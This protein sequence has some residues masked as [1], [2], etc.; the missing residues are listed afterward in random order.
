MSNRDSVAGTI[1]PNLFINLR[2]K[3]YLKERRWLRFWAATGIILQAG[4]LAFSG[5]ATYHPR[6]KYAKEG[7]LVEPHAYPLAAVGTAILVF[8]MWLC[9][10]V[11]ESSTID[12]IWEVRNVKSTGLDS[13]KTPPPENVRIIWLQQGGSVTDQQ[14]DSYAIITGETVQSVLTS[15]LISWMRQEPIPDMP[16]QSDHTQHS[17]QF[18]HQNKSC[19]IANSMAQV[20][21]SKGFQILATA[22]AFIGIGG[23]VIQFTGFRSTHF[24]VTVAQLLVTAIMILIRAW[25]RR[26]LIAKPSAYKIP[27]GYEMD[28]LATRLALEPDKLWPSSRSHCPTS[29]KTQ[30]A[31]AFASTALS[32]IK[33]TVKHLQCRAS[34]DTNLSR[35]SPIDCSCNF[36]SESCWDWGVKSGQETES[37]WFRPQPSSIL[38]SSCHQTMKLRERIG[39][40]SKWAGPVTE[41]AISLSSAIEVVMNSL[42]KTEVSKFESIMTWTMQGLHTHGNTDDDGQIYFSIERQRGVWK[43]SAT[44][45][46]AFLSLWMFSIHSQRLEREQIADSQDTDRDWL[47][48]GENAITAPGLRLLGSTN[49]GS[50]YLRDLRWY[51]GDAFD[52][53]HTLKPVAPASNAH[54]GQ[55]RICTFEPQLI[56]GFEAPG[57]N[58]ASVQSVSSASTTPT[59]NAMMT[60]HLDPLEAHDTFPSTKRLPGSIPSNGRTLAVFSEAP[61]EYHLVQ[62]MFSTFFWAVARK[63]ARLSGTTTVLPD[64]K[65][66]STEDSGWESFRLQNDQLSRLVNDISAVSGGWLGNNDEI[67]LSIVPQLR[68]SDKLPIPVIVID[69]ARYIALPY[70]ASGSWRGVLPVYLFLQRCCRTFGIGSEMRRRTIANIMDF[71]SRMGIARREREDFNVDLD[72]ITDARDVELQLINA[73][74]QIEEDGDED[75]IHLLR[76]F[77]IQNRPL[78]DLEN[79]ILSK[80]PLLLQILRNQV[81]QERRELAFP[82]STPIHESILGVVR[83]ESS[84]EP[85]SRYNSTDWQLHQ[86]NQQDDFGLTPL[87][88]FLFHF[89]AAIWE[90]EFEK[91][92]N[93]IREGIENGKGAPTFNVDLADITGWSILHYAAVKNPTPL[94]KDVITNHHPDLI[95]ELPDP[96]DVGLLARF[97][98]LELP[99]RNSRHGFAPDLSGRTPFHYVRTKEQA[100]VLL[101]YGSSSLSKV[102]RDGT[103][104]LL[105]AT[106]YKREA[107]AEVLL[108]GNADPKASD[109]YRRTAFHWAA[110]HSFRQLP[111]KLKRKGADLFALDA[112]NRTPLHWSRLAEGM[113]LALWEMLSEDAETVDAGKRTVLHLGAMAG[114]LDLSPRGIFSRDPECW[115]PEKLFRKTELTVPIDNFDGRGLTALGKA[116]SRGHDRAVETLLDFGADINFTGL[117]FWGKPLQLAVSYGHLSTTKLLLSRGA[118]VT[119]GGEFGPGENAQFITRSGK[120]WVGTLTNAV[121]SGTALRIIPV[122]LEMRDE[123]RL[124]SHD[125]LKA[126]Q[127]AVARGDEEAAV[128]LIDIGCRIKPLHLGDTRS[129]QVN[130]GDEGSAEWLLAEA[131]FRGICQA[132]S[133][134]LRQRGVDVNRVHK[135]HRFLPSISFKLEGEGSPDKSR[136]K[137]NQRWQNWVDPAFELGGT[138]L[139]HAA[140]AGHTD[141][142]RILI[143]KGADLNLEDV[144]GR[145]ALW[146]AVFG[147]HEGVVRLLLAAGSAQLGTLDTGAQTFKP[148]PVPTE[149]I[150]WLLRCNG[151]H[152]EPYMEPNDIARLTHLSRDPNQTTPTP[153][154]TKNSTIDTDNANILPTPSFK[155]DKTKARPSGSIAQRKQLTSTTDRGRKSL[156]TGTTQNSSPPPTTPISPTTK[157]QSK[158][159][160]SPSLPPIPNFLGP[161]KLNLSS[162]SDSTKPPQPSLPPNTHVRPPYST[163]TRIS[164]SKGSVGSPSNNPFGPPILC[165]PQSGPLARPPSSTASGITT[166]AHHNTNSIGPTAGSSRLSKLLSI[167]PRSISSDEPDTRHPK[168][169]NRKIQTTKSNEPFSPP[170]PSKVVQT[171]IHQASDSPQPET[172][173]PST[174]RKLKQSRSDPSIS[175]PIRPL[176]PDPTP[177]SPPSVG[178]PGAFL[179]DATVSNVSLVSAGSTV[180]WG[181]DW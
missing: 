99:T 78:W 156:G 81:P 150:Q 133:S 104:A 112:A 19:G 77:R 56:L 93:T 106:R 90:K 174:P 3:S 10:Y 111:K 115:K 74:C 118:E 116:A 138:A 72:A 137:F 8:G 48:D 85:G 67:L 159:P 65:S 46:E 168:T 71:T 145:T 47:R 53:I 16:A 181:E 82:G 141:V 160:A 40:L 172:I 123:I 163:N 41:G 180:S 5:F 152:Y 91:L 58:E 178:M 86:Y 6:M 50:S 73:L 22:G 14:F 139:Y 128:F 29:N 143:K 167:P 124:D 97:L 18:T 169:S 54:P 125:G 98:Q 49:Y 144:C 170:S 17:P 13:T 64:S 4:V 148:L 147:G 62:D 51:L 61:T 165:L 68:E 92:E 153:I 15:R 108:D 28:W 39:Q 113:P 114:A 69:Y 76:L 23:F 35:H 52:E 87:H 119:E 12:Q 30:Q 155:T 9:S 171:S 34:V 132:V 57:K 173:N 24:S 96:P 149:P 146:K 140:R 134:I 164:T 27:Q 161:S 179:P 55:G 110:F 121:L 42:F 66:D 84:L 130:T 44:E 7:E 60:F 107:V 37:F 135:G 70:E 80:S 31:P 75:V 102:A 36:F 79:R 120:L 131:S 59:V 33:R 109:C 166:D 88:Y 43:C 100:E 2:S 89:P 142:A 105:A 176:T 21:P 25:V 177:P 95:A 175:I 83:S 32:T 127:N 63:M 162:Q 154:N 151:I 117:E 101:R 158:E 129:V 122:L 38:L 45:I 136:V 11:V 103:S 157:I 94:P 126:V 20:D 1:A 26:K